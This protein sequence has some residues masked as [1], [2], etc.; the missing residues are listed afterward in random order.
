[1]TPYPGTPFFARLKQED[2]IKTLDWSK[3]DLFFHVVYKPQKLAAYSVLAWFMIIRLIAMH[4]STLGI[5]I[6]FL[7]DLCPLWYQYLRQYYFSYFYG[8]PI[9]K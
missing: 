9:F 3:Y 7:V 1:M 8:I 4:T 5:F 6:W 2:R